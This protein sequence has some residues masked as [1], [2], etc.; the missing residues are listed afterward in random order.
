[1]ENKTK[2]QLADEAYEQHLPKIILTFDEEA[3]RIGA[4]K[5]GFKEG[6]D[7]RQP[8]IDALAPKWINVEESLPEHGQIV[9]LY[10]DTYINTTTGD[11]SYSLQCFRK[12]NKS[13]YGIV[14]HWMP[15]HNPPKQTKK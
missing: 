14:T 5:V 12:H 6:Y 4:F 10:S 3:Q 9:L 8:E 2:E 15:L 13:D 1:M 11:Y 7:A